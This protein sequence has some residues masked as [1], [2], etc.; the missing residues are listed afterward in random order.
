MPAVRPELGPREGEA[1]RLC[2][3]GFLLLQLG[4]YRQAAL[5][6]L[7]AMRTAR[8]HGLSAPGWAG[9]AY[10]YR[11]LWQQTGEPRYLRRYL[12]FTRERADALQV[13]VA[14]AALARVTAR[15]RSARS[16]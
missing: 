14:R 2:R 13:G 1:S 6:Y 4:A 9:L 5:C 10:A 7:R 12:R 16:P 15:A 3:D 8:R 11:A